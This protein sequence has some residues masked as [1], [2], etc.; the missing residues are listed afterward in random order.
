[1]GIVSA[2]YNE[3]ALDP[4]KAL[5]YYRNPSAILVF[6]NATKVTG[7]TA[8]TRTL[9]SAALGGGRGIAID[10]TRDLLYVLEGDN[11]VLVFANASTANGAVTPLHTISGAAFSNAG[12]IA[13]DTTNDRLYV[14][15][16]GNV[17][18]FNNASTANGAIAATRTITISGATLAAFGVAV[19]VTSDI[20]YIGSRNVGDIYSV[21]ASTANGA[22]V[23]TRTITGL[24]VPMGV[25]V[26]GNRL[27]SVSDNNSDLVS[28][29]NNADNQNGAVAPDALIQLPTITAESGFAYAP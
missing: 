12:G 29:W 17:L 5:L 9:T 10:T 27:F 4:T 13:I 22:V 14:A 21:P 7:N 6:S 28:A 23:P 11:S 19:D 26:F 16:L 18:V 3:L 20:L 8:P 25:G 2:D 24:N 15:D 1:V